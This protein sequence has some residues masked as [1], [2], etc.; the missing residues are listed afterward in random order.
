MPIIPSVPFEFLLAPIDRRRRIL[1]P[2]NPS[3]YMNRMN[4]TGVGKEQLGHCHC[5]Y[6]EMRLEFFVSSRHGGLRVCGS[7]VED[8]GFYRGLRGRAVKGPNERANSSRRREVGRL[9]TE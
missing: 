8:I 1:E 4:R 7:S 3:D 5:P 9:G 6:F 2:K